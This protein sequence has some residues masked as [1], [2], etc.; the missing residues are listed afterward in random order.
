[1]PSSRLFDSSVDIMFN[2]TV[3]NFVYCHSFYVQKIN[4]WKWVVFT[5]LDGFIY[6]YFIYGLN[7]KERIMLDNEL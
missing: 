6:I 7:D 2:V 5:S 3:L 1:M 4:F